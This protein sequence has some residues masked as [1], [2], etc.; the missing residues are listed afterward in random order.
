MLG[1][2]LEDNFIVAGTGHR[3][4]YCP[5]KYKKSHPWLK[6]LQGRLKM[7]LS[8]INTM[9]RGDII[10]RAGGAI[11]WD[12]WLAQ[13]ALHLGLELHLYLPF[14]DQGK[15]WPSDSLE[16][17]EKIKELASKVNFTAEEYYPRVFFDRDQQM[18]VGSHQVVSLLNPEASS[19]GTFYTVGEAE[20]LDIPVIN[21][22]KD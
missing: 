10:V 7:Y 1:V 6:E 17:Y 14:P 12:T 22:W 20:K 18:I 16:E 8:G 15:A 9:A 11:G 13:T 21:F 2:E 3:P 4:K 5:C 19:G